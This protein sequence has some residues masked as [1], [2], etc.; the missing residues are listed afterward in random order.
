M[1]LL[2]PFILQNFKKI[3]RANQE[4]WQCAIFKPKMAH[5]FWKFFFGTDHHHYFHLSI[6]PFIVQNLKKLLQRLQSYEHLPFLGPKWSICPKQKLFLQIINII[7]IYPLA[8]FIVPNFKKNL[9]VDPE[10]WGCAI[11]GSK[12]SISP[13]LMCKLWLIFW[14]NMKIWFNCLLHF[15]WRRHCEK[16]QNSIWKIL[17]PTQKDYWCCD[18]LSFKLW[19]G[20]STSILN[21]N[22]WYL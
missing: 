1:Y 5:L 16:N 3:L 11:F 10:L 8:P 18:W 4:L 19:H 21:N 22:I 13:I 2:V 20:N 7:L 12:M 15:M 14:N 17:L 9:P 6:G